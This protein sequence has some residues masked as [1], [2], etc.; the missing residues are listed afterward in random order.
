MRHEEHGAG[1]VAALEPSGDD[2]QA[3]AGVGI[4]NCERVEIDAELSQFASKVVGDIGH[5][6]G[7]CWVR[8][9]S[10]GGDMAQS[11]PG[12]EC[13]ARGVRPRDG[14]KA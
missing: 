13:L 6:L 9:P 12:R 2:A 14:W 11:A 3:D 5:R 8:V 4:T 1:R 7:S 10:D